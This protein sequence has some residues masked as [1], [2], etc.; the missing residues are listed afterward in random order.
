M[1]GIWE[2]NCTCL[3]VSRFVASLRN[4]YPQLTE[5]YFLV[6]CTLIH[7]CGNWERGRAVSFPGI[8]K[9]DLIYSVAFEPFHILPNTEANVMLWIVKST[10]CQNS[11]DMAVQVELCICSMTQVISK[12]FWMQWLWI[13]INGSPVVLY[14]ASES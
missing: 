1:G 8:H 13:Y 9:S 7:K 10:N 5:S 11:L 14:M 12:F 6:F 2:F 4:T 3:I